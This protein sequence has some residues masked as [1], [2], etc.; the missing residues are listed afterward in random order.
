M[1]S[2]IP[3]K[4]AEL[5]DMLIFVASILYDA[6]GRMT[7]GWRLSWSCW[8]TIWGWGS[9][10]RIHLFFGEGTRSTWVESYWMF[11]LVSLDLSRNSFSLLTKPL[12]VHQLGQQFSPV[13]HTEP[14]GWAVIYQLRMNRS[15]DFRCEVCWIVN[16][17]EDALTLLACGWGGGRAHFSFEEGS[18]VV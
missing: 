3:L 13:F 6:A 8:H 17:S 2:I 12:P 9:G 4:V 11:L 10:G 18:K 5:G 14:Q 1:I 15:C 7:V 16:V